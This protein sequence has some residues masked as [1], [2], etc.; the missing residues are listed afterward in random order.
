MEELRVPKRRVPA[1][2]VLPGGAERRVVLFLAEAAAD[3]SGAEQ[4]GDLLNGP[5]DFFP[6]L[7]EL[8]GAMTFLHRGA[9]AVVRVARTLEA[10]CAE[11]LTLPTEHEV[12]VHLADGSCRTGLVSYLRPPDRARLVDFLNEAPPFFRLLEADAVALVNKRH[13]TRVVLLSR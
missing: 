13:V 4:P 2:V 1:E 10:D 5:G 8:A 11:A 9:V 6:A 12:E 7:D 3:H